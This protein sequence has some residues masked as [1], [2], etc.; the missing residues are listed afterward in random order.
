MKQLRLGIVGTGMAFERLHW[1]ALQQLQEQYK[2]VIRETG[3][4]VDD[5]VKSVDWESRVITVQG[6]GGKERYVTLVDQKW[7]DTKFRQYFNEAREKG[8]V[9][10]GKLG[11]LWDVS[12]R[13]LQRWEQRLRGQVR[14]GSGSGCHG[15]RGSWAQEKYRDLINSGWSTYS[16]KW[17]M[18]RQL[19]HN[20]LDVLKEYGIL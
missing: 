20:R 11:K 13:T 19:G 14:S 8:L 18:T 9:A 2:E 7:F 16:A 17:E 6:K 12:T 15:L 4:R 5:K 3:L 1:P 10:A